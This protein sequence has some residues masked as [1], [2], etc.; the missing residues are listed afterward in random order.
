LKSKI[1]PDA[2]LTICSYRIR[3]DFDSNEK[4]RIYGLP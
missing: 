4:E 1:A 3:E 2:K